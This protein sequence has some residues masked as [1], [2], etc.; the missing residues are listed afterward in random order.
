MRH[1]RGLASIE[2]PLMPSR[3][4]RAAFGRLLVSPTGSHARLTA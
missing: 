2:V 4:M 1:L 3:V